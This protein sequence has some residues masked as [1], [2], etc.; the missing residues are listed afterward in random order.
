M[1]KIVCVYFTLSVYSKL[2]G[3]HTVY[4]I[5]ILCKNLKF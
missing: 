3:L 2:E 5:A 4:D 1:E